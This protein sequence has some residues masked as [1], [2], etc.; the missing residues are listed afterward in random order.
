M[1]AGRFLLA[2]VL[3]IAVVVVTNILLPPVPPPPGT[4]G[5]DSLSAPPAAP[6]ARPPRVE[7][8]VPPAAVGQPEAVAQPATVG[9]TTD[10]G[11]E[12]DTLF[13]ESPL[14]RLGF[15]TRGGGL[16]S[17]ELSQYESHSD[18][19]SPVQLVPPETD[20]LVSYRLRV[21]DRTIDLASLPVASAAATTLVR[22]APDSLRL[23]YADSASGFGF[24]LVYRFA[25]NEYLID[26]EVRV[27]GL[28]DATPQLLI[29][30]GPRLP[31]H[32]WTP[33]EDR[34]ALAYVVNSPQRGIESLS[35]SKVRGQKIENGPLLWAALKN[36]YFVV[37]LLRSTG[38]PT[39]F[40]GLV[41]DSVGQD[42]ATL[43]ATLDPSADGTF[44]YRIYLGPQQYERL[45]AVGDR[46]TDV[47]P[48]GW[49]FLRPVMQP[50]AFGITWL[51]TRMHDAFNL[52]YGWVL[53]LFGVL[54]RVVLWPLN[55]KA[56]RS[57]MKNMELQPR[58]KEL[59]TKYKSD[60]ERMN[61]EMM[62]L[63]KEEGFN[64][65][66]GCLP[67]LIP[68]P[69]LIALFFVFQ[70]TIEFRGV[71]FLWLPDLSRADPLYI[72]PVLM[73]LSM[74]GLQW[75]SLRSTPD[76]TP[77]MKMMM[78]LMP[79]MMTVLFLNFASGLNLY[80]TAMNV[81]SLPQQMYLVK[82]RRKFQARGRTKEVAAAR[83]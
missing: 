13:V 52:A 36:K 65:F 22:A 5:V 69:V 32:E 46:F 8:D 53:I 41:A 28:G 42:A 61:K 44:R 67:L 58:I 60:P 79:G 21:G 63:Y 77:Q 3:M 1:E 82:E 11:I 59:Q 75:F 4:P 31:F 76:P 55:T 43:T 74:F 33:D 47:N 37:A 54:V 73:G 56:M 35:L 39:P 38:Q 10:E 48:V 2:V 26:A 68:M 30:F 64:P 62:R 34:R 40:G 19:G 49:K 18:P 7:P 14:F 6:P 15:S 45:A 71:P 16:A 78:W 23:T 80:Y 70:A 27:A 66:G 50:I 29:D 17:A 24:D 72:I 83:G 25:P 9:P 51:I 12:V 20:A 57:Q 81:A